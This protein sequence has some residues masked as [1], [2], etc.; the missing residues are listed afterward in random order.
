MRLL[1]RTCNFD[2]KRRVLQR[3]GRQEGAER[4]SSLAYE[5]QSSIIPEQNTS[6]H[7]RHHY[8]RCHYNNS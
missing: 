2:T 7:R 8:R 1:R 3:A 4:Q 6:R 5:L